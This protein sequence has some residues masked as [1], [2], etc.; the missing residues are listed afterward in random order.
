MSTYSYVVLL[1]TGKEKKGSMDA[2]S[3]EAAM[4]ALKKEGNTVMSIAEA[5]VLNKDLEISF[6]EKKP[7]PRDLAV[8]CR[9]F[10]S[11]ID[12]GVPVI[13]AFE[14]LGEQTENKKLKK[15]VLECKKTI[16]HGETL[17]NAMA[18]FPEVFPPMFVTLVEAGEASGSL[19]IS[20]A[21]MADQFEKEAALKAT[22]KKAT[23]YPIMIGIIAVAAI[24]LLLRFVVPAFEDMLK[25][26]GSELPA[27]TKFVIA[28]SQ[29]I[30]TRWYI[31]AVVVIALVLGIKIFKNSPAGARFF[32]MA[33]IKVPI[34]KNLT[35]KSSAARLARTLSTLIGAGLPLIDALTITAGTM[36]NIWFKEEVLKARDQV[37]VGA[38]LAKQFK[39]GGM[40]PPLLHQMVSI[41]E[42]TGD[43]DNMLTK[44]A[45]YY[46]DE[47]K[48]A[49]E[50]LMAVLEPLIILVLAVVIGGIVLSVIAPMASMYDGLNNL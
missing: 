44:L 29:F 4:E 19:D 3:R 10:V 7:K 6:L 32:G 43:I 24:V 9:Q 40:F 34:T 12:A 38:P 49:T 18:Q 13:T 8:F 45:A 47:V 17:A 36:T 27:I 14:M 48:A 31:C 26:L 16:E 46:E 37:M 42:D 15:A 33:A 11:I 22:V 35:V 25:D 41:G 39:E 50:Q 23:T 30:Q 20:F 2:E 1:S 21:R 5:G 28:A